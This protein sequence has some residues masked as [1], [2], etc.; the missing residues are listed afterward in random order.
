MRYA[1]LVVINLPIILLALLGSVTQYKLKR[2]NARRYKQQAAYWT[3][4]L[5]VLLLSFPVYNLL[6]H[7]PLFDSA[8]LSLIDITESTAIIYLFYIINNQRRKIEQTERLVRDLHQEL[9]IKL[10]EK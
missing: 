8:K 10:S 9:S 6:N 7:R 2:I 1:F 3:L 4:L 5:L